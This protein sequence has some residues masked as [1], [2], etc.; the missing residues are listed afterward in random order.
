MTGVYSGVYG[1]VSGVWGVIIPRVVPTR[2]IASISIS[3]VDFLLGVDD[4]TDVMLLCSAGC[5]VSTLYN[6]STVSG[7]LC[8]VSWAMKRR[9]SGIVLSACS[10]LSAMRSVR[11]KR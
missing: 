3:C 2:V 10:T 11:S 9:V 6:S 1:S 5:R 4:V 7:I 8:S